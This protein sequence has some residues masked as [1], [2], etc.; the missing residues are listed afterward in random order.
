MA[1]A[2]N[3]W[4]I[5]PAKKRAPVSVSM[6]AEVEAKARDLIEKVLK[7]KHVLPPKEGEEFNYI[8]EIGAKW[9]RNY[10]YFFSIYTCPSP[11]AL[12]PTFEAMFARMEPLGD[13]T[14]ALYAMRHTGKEWVGVLDALTV[15]ECMK[16]IQD[17][18]WFVL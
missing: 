17:D 18:D 6:K 11:N 3:P 9:N 5:S 13:G 8:S 7:P 1:N 14:F 2:R 4:D 15:D 16:A 12:T 10:F